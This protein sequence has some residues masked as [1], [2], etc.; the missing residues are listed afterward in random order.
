MNKARKVPMDSIRSEM[1]S[2]LTEPVFTDATIRCND[3]EF[4]VHRA[5]LALQSPVFKKMLE[6]DMKEKESEVVDLS[7]YSEPIVSDLVTY[8]YT[9]SAPSIG[10]LAYDLLT[11]A[12]M[13]E[14]HRLFVMCE[15]ELMMKI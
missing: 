14:L 13:Y 5:I 9:G 15:N 12:S 8:L 4:K 6:T 3:K 7:D 11:V 2:L 1:G 10:S